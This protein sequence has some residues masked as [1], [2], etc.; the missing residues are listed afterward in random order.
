MKMVN[1][2]VEPPR[3]VVLIDELSEMLLPS[4]KPKATSLL[5]GENGEPLTGSTERRKSD[6][7]AAET[8]NLL[9]VIFRDTT[10]WKD[11]L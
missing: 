9:A 11:N 4:R 8:M 7:A 10:L 2:P 6:N 1:L 5:E 3:R